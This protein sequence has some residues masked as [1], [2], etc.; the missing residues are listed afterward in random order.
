MQHEGGTGGTGQ[1][2]ARASIG[3]SRT[4]R[5]A[6]L[7]RKAMCRL[8]DRWGV[9][10]R[11]TF[12][13][14]TQTRHRARGLLVDNTLRAFRVLLGYASSFRWTRHGLVNMASGQACHLQYLV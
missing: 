6:D 14:M 11:G 8:L 12:R 9:L 1:S 10:G 13:N 5:C 2:F 4:L 3:T 7:R